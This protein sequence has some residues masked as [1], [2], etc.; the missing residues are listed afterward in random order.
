M[1][2]VLVSACLV[3]QAVRYDGMPATCR[4]TILARW[5][6]EGRVVAF[7]PEV[8]AGAPVP[9]P[10]VELVGGDGRAVLGGAAR[11]L[12][13]NGRDQTGLLIEGARAAA[14][15]CARRGIRVAVLKARSP[16]CGSDGIHDGSF[17]GA[18]TPGDGVA[19]SALRECG[20]AVFGEA[21][22]TE[23]DASLRAN[24]APSGR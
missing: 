20:V 21:R 15:L 7:C 4:S 16:S 17:A 19:A 6:S 11:A 13:A 12:E 10:P 22:L 2:K 24:E 5:V 14:D 23:A 3:G 18:L 8:Q 9:R 1:E